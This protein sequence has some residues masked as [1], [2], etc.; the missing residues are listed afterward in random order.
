ML[1]AIASGARIDTNQTKRFYERLE[2]IYV[3]P[4]VKKAAQPQTAEEIKQYI[5]SRLE[6]YIDG[7][8]DSG[9]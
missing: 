9:G 3:N 5:I 7:S 1:Y 2:D 4:F 8:D 6:V